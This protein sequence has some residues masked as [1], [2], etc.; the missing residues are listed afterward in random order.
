MQAERGESPTYEIVRETGPAHNKTFEAIVKI[1]NVKLGRGVGKS[2]K[3]AEQEAAK[4]A[5][6]KLAK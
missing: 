3:D 2:K 4:N 6:D 5:I 1:E